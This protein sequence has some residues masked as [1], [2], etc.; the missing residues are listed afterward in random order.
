[1]PNIYCGSKATPHGKVAGT[2]NQCFR[3][4]RRAG[5]VG[6]ISKN[7]I[8][9]AEVIQMGN[10]IHQRP[11]QAIAKALGIAEYA[12][13]KA[14]LLPIVLAHNWQRVNAKDVLLNL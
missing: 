3:Q 1:M 14:E 8:T 2:K 9:K 13:K 4:G 5:F 10:L 12:L 11:L 6:G 7:N